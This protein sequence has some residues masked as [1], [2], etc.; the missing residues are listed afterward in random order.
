MGIQNNLKICD[1]FYIS[2]LYS[3]ANKFLWL[4]NSAWDFFGVKF[5]SRDFLWVLIFFH[6]LIIP[7]TWIHSTPPGTGVSFGRSILLQSCSNF[8][9]KPR[10]ETAYCN[11]LF[12]RQRC[13]GGF[14]Y[15]FAQTPSGDS[16]LLRFL[17]DTCNA[18]IWMWN[19]ILAMNPQHN[20]IYI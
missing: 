11:S 13:L 5:W 12:S 16:K 1:S 10:L 17:P 2:Q 3:S 8:E 14:V 19:L 7:V 15:W 9:L 6:H 4:R 18:D 20:T